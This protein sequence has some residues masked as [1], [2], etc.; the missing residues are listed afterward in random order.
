MWRTTECKLLTDANLAESNDDRVLAV[1]ISRHCKNLGEK[2]NP[3]QEHKTTEDRYCRW[4]KRKLFSSSAF[5]VLQ[6]QV[7][8]QRTTEYKPST[9]HCF[10]QIRPSVKGAP[11]RQEWATGRW[12]LRTVQLK[13]LL[14]H[15]QMT[16][17]YNR[18]FSKYIMW[19]WKG[20]KIICTHN[21]L[22]HHLNLKNG[23]DTFCKSNRLSVVSHSTQLLLII[24]WRIHFTHQENTLRNTCSVFSS[25][26][27]VCVSYWHKVCPSDRE[28][29][30]KIRLSHTKS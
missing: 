25:S 6:V 24:L 13:I 14:Y 19:H 8:K 7:Q 21:S 9:H 2:K 16:A 18:S 11:Q 27:L 28:K 1:T 30:L 17:F 3:T 22:Y 26:L 4:L 20:A 5:F 29:F 12:A 10:E 15:P 23:S